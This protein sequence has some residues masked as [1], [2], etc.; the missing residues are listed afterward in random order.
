MKRSLLVESVILVF[1]ALC[2]LPA[3]AEPLQ[4]VGGGG[5]GSRVLEGACSGCHELALITGS[6]KSK[7]EWEETVTEMEQRGA[8]LLESERPLLIDF[9]AQSYGLESNAP[10]PSP[11]WTNSAAPTDPDARG[12]RVAQEAC[13]VCHELEL[14]YQSRRSASE[15]EGLVNDMIGRGAAMLDGEREFL[16]QFL[17]KRY[18]PENA[19]TNINQASAEQLV[20][21]FG[22]TQSEAEAVVR[23]R[24][25]KEAILGWED[26]RNVPGLNVQKLVDKRERLAFF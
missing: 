6:K 9:L 8:P 10:T 24:Q 2:Y 17:V 22:L 20:S 7:T 26:L 13:S 14:I 12:R 21:E 18:G 23:F 25:Q 3:S 16:L 1:V 15:W 11:Q 5:P 4:E 19:K